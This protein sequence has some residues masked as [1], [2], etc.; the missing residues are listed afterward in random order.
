LYSQAE[1]KRLFSTFI[2]T[3]DDWLKAEIGGS[4]SSARP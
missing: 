2:E 1:V 4:P 3:V